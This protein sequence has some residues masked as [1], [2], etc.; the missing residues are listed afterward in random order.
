MLPHTHHTKPHHTPLTSRSHKIL[1][2]DFCRRTKQILLCTY[3]SIVSTV[4]YHGA[5]QPA[6]RHRPRCT[7]ARGVIAGPRCQHPSIHALPNSAGWRAWTTIEYRLG[8]RAAGVLSSVARRRWRADDRCDGDG[9]H[10]WHVISNHIYHTYRLVRALCFFH[11]FIH[12]TYCTYVRTHIIYN[13]QHAHIPALF[14]LLSFLLFSHTYSYLPTYLHCVLRSIG[15]VIWGS[16]SCVALG[17]GGT[18]VVA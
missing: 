5:S 2:G 12:N 4:R 7:I 17:C 6:L 14:C 15:V 18:G 13:L 8:G 16:R 3:L 10:A 1:A 9:R 11:F